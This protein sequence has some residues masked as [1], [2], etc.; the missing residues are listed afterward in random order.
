M[1]DGQ[2]GE[3]SG[4]GGAAEIVRPE[5]LPESYWDA[6][7]KA[8][9]YDV[10]GN[11]LTELTTLR[12]ER[13]ARE[14]AIPKEGKYAFELPKDFPIPNGQKWEA[15]A[16]D[17]LAKAALDYAVANKLTQEQFTGLNG[18]WANIQ[19]E[20]A[21]AEREAIAKETA[22]LGE[23]ADTRRTAVKT[24]LTSKDASGLTKDQAD[25]LIPLLSY[26]HGV[27]ALEAL[28]KLAAG[29]RAKGN[30]GNGADTSKIEQLAGKSGIELLRAANAGTRG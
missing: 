7:A 21:K 8:P 16:E 4:G 25:S 19:L 27:E 13:T 6:E 30:P 24:W 20:Q 10:L 11:D 5:A 22:A 2:E 29:P 23:K 1:A 3:G 15:H 26:R 28:Q 9:K 18:V 14:A 17:P 12:T